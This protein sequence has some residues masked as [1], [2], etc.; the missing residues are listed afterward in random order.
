MHIHVH[1]TL[2]KPTLRGNAYG[3]TSKANA[4][5]Y[6][7]QLFYKHNALNKLACVRLRCANRTYESI[8]VCTMRFLFSFAV[9]PISRL[10]N[11]ASDPG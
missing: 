9:S 5:F 10:P 6:K 1:F 11:S 2:A 3:G 8:K 7:K 4:T